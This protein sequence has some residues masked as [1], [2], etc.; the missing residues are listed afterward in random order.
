MRAETTQGDIE[1]KKLPRNENI[2]RQQALKEVNILQVW[3]KLFRQGFREEGGE[4]RVPDDLRRRRHRDLHRDHRRDRLLGVD[5]DLHRLYLRRDHVR[6]RR[7][8]S[9]PLLRSGTAAGTKL[10]K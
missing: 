4:L 2:P 1:I 8:T 5:D 10:Q 3:A 6:V 7:S 9:L